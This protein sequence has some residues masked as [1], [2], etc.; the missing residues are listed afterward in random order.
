VIELQKT[1]LNNPQSFLENNLH[2]EICYNNGCIYATANYIAKYLNNKNDNRASKFEPLI[3]KILYGET[4]IRDDIDDDMLNN[5][6]DNL[7]N[8]IN[9]HKK[10]DILNILLDIGFIPKP[11]ILFE[12]VCQGNRKFLK[13]LKNREISFDV[14]NNDGINVIEYAISLSKGNIDVKL[15]K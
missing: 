1:E 3:E 11:N 10:V 12:L 2:Y 5:E 8:T 14:L 6:R 13:I 15:Q 7:C 9:I 4:I